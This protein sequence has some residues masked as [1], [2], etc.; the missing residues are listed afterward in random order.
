MKKIQK[1][2][3][4]KYL[5]LKILN[6]CGYN[7]R[8][9]EYHGRF[10]KEKDLFGIADIL[11]FAGSELLWIQVTSNVKHSNKPYIDFVKQHKARVIQIVVL[12]GRSYLWLDYLENSKLSFD[13]TLDLK[14]FLINLRGEYE[15]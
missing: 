4:R 11:A 2:L 1:G 12:D 6:E 15:K 13:S 14:D 7:C 8:N 3:R 5:I 10:R 9:V